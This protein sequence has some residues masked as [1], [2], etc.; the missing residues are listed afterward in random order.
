M[1]RFVE[2]VREIEVALGS[3]RRIL[4]DEERKKR[5]AIRR[6]LHVAGDLPMGHVLTEADI[7]YRRPGTG[8]TPDRLQEVLSRP[9]TVK[10][11]AGQRLEWDDLG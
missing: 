9:L 10:K 5:K 8:I 11:S 3:S 2:V 7:D 4:S 1:R 6:S